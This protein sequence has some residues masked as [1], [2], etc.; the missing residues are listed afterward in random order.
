MKLA[1]TSTLRGVVAFGL[2]PQAE[3]LDQVSVALEVTLLQVLQEAAT[4]ADELEQAS[5]RMVVFRVSSEMLGE[6]VDASR[7]ERD[8]H[9]GRAGVLLA[10][11]VL[12]DDVLLRFLGEGQTASF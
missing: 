10:A 8:L 5:A 6:L 3:L 1:Q 11:P 12:A 7:E 2:P 4:P 9:V